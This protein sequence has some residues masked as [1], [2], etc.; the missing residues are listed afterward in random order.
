MNEHIKFQLGTL[1]INILKHNLP[2][3]GQRKTSLVVFLW[4]RRT[5]SVV[6]LTTILFLM[7][8][9]RPIMLQS[10]NREELVSQK[11]GE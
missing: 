1:H 4:K 8:Q 5:S 2:I 7:A 3:L 11:N 9:Y 10:V 6:F